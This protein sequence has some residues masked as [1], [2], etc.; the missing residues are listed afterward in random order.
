MKNKVPGGVRELMVIALPMMISQVCE[1]TMMFIGRYFLASL[2]P[3]QMSAAMGAGLACFVLMTFFMGLTGFAGALVAQYLGSGQKHRCPVVVT[4]A[5]IVCLLAAPL[6]IAC[7]PLGH[8]LFEVSGIAQRQLVFQIQYFDIVVYGAVVGLLR[9]TF[10]SFFSGIGRTR[11]AIVSAGVALVVDVLSNYLL[12]FGNYGFPALGVRGAALSNI[13]GG[14]SALCVLLLRYFSKSYREQYQTRH[15]Y[16]Y[17][18]EIMLKLWRYGSPSGFEFFMNI[19]AFNLLVLTFHSYGVVAAAALTIMI[20]WE[21]LSFIPLIGIGM[22]VSSLVGRYMGA[23][24]PDTAH[25]AA[26]SGVKVAAI[27][28]TFSLII[29]CVFPHWMVELFRPP[30]ETAESI[31]IA[32]LAEYMLRLVVFY[33]FADAMTVVFSN[34]LRGAGDTFWSMVISVTGHWSFAIASL[35]MVRYLHFEPRLTW[36]VIVVFVI[37]IGVSLYLRYRTG[38]WRSLKVVEPIAP[39]QYEEE[40]IAV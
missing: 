25:R 22:G 7:R 39:L 19:F 5:V 2:G 6:I 36:A 12:I 1:T 26:M 4:Q 18:Q 9:N 20:N 29:F 34:A 33:L 10:S 28:T 32:S 40:N 3:E 17:D 14:V 38:K 13:I 8:W 21:M 15:S 27:Y 30:V 23:Q 24:D 11:I 35:V 31:A 37:A 16:K